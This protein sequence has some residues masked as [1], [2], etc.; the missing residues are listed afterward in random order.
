MLVSPQSQTPAV[1]LADDAAGE[2]WEEC[3]SVEVSEYD[4]LL[5]S[6]A[7]LIVDWE[8]G[9]NGKNLQQRMCQIVRVHG[10]VARDE[11]VALITRLEVLGLEASDSK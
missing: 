9:Q 1:R 3:L 5:R 4:R 6:R 2:H 10:G 11:D 8:G 7:A